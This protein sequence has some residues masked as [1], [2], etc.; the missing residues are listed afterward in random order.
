MDSIISMGFHSVPVYLMTKSSPSCAPGPICPPLRSDFTGI[1]DPGSL[2]SVVLLYRS[3]KLLR[4]CLS[5]GFKMKSENFLIV[6]F[7]HQKGP[8]RQKSKLGWSPWFSRFHPYY[9]CR[10]IS[11]IIRKFLM[12]K[13]DYRFGNRPQR[14]HLVSRV[15]SLVIIKGDY[16]CTPQCDQRRKLHI[17]I[18]MLQNIWKKAQS[19]EKLKL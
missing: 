18:I 7:Q 16:T 9:H 11:L 4:F 8:V 1:G 19:N 3:A 15:L 2:F 17:F 14:N 13:S 6:E 10:K 12:I 5:R